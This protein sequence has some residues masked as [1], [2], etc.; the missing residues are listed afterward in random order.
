MIIDYIVRESINGQYK[1][2]KV[3]L[4]DG[5]KYLKTV[6]KLNGKKEAEDLAHALFKKIPLNQREQ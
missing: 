2:K 3:I 4:L 1:V 5:K 6:K